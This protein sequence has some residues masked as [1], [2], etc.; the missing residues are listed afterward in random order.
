MY[1]TENKYVYVM[2]VFI[3][4]K[5]PHSGDCLVTGITKHVQINLFLHIALLT[6]PAK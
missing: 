3:F 4:F 2:Y 1:W 5:D 6:L